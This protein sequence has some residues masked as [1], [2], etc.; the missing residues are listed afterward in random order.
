MYRY[1]RWDKMKNPHN[2]NLMNLHGELFK[3]P[4]I[5]SPR[6]K[7]ANAEVSHVSSRPKEMRTKTNLNSNSAT[8]IGAHCGAGGLARSYLNPTPHCTFKFIL[9]LQVRNLLLLC[10]SLHC[11]CAVLHSYSRTLRLASIT[12]TWYVTTA[13]RVTARTYVRNLNL[14]YVILQVIFVEKWFYRCQARLHI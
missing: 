7:I 11:T 6:Q 1:L 5:F 12:Y 8:N 14:C 10:F 3:L 4:Y 13:T 2:L 9:R